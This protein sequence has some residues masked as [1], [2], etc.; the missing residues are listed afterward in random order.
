MK[1]LALLLAPASFVAQA[2][3]Y[4]DRERDWRSGAIVGH[5]RYKRVP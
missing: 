2:S 3:A 5:N 4:E 1:R